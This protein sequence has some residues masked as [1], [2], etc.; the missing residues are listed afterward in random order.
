MFFP[1]LHWKFFLFIALGMVTMLIFKLVSEFLGPLWICVYFLL[2]L[3][4]FLWLSLAFLV[5][6]GGRD[7]LFVKLF[8]KIMGSHLRFY[9]NREDLPLLPPRAISN[10]ESSQSNFRIRKMWSVP[11][12]ACHLWFIHSSGSS[13]CSLSPKLRGHLGVSITPSHRMRLLW[14][15]QHFFRSGIKHPQRLGSLTV[16]DFHSPQLL[17]K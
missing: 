13:L 6:L 2:F 9:S 10:L 4:I 17:T 3:L 1:I 11:M 16:L 7:F 14:S 8:L 15:P 5:G 12:R